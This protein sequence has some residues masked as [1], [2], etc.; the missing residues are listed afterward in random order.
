LLSAALTR[1]SERFR[2]SVIPSAAEGILAGTAQF[3][4]MGQV[5]DPREIERMIL[6]LLQDNG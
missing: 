1:E 3:K 4:H 5:P 6:E 2:S